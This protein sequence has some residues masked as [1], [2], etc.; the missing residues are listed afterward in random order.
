MTTK[1]AAFL[2]AVGMP[3]I[4]VPRH[5]GD[6]PTSRNDEQVRLEQADIAARCQRGFASLVQAPPAVGVN[7]Q[8]HLINAT[9]CLDLVHADALMHLT[10]KTD[11]NQWVSSVLFDLHTMDYDEACAA[12]LQDHGLFQQAPELYIG[13]LHAYWVDSTTGYT[14]RH[15]VYEHNWHEEVV[16]F[17]LGHPTYELS[18]NFGVGVV[19][20]AEAEAFHG[21]LAFE[22]DAHE[23]HHERVYVEET[24]EQTPEQKPEKTDEEWRACI[25][26]ALLGL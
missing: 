23:N 25:D 3:R 2:A 10:P 16:P 4:G 18:L 8:Y 26:P 17:L 22:N 11:M 5:A 6:R 21:D 20:V 7:P 12:I 9:L 15:E 14:L 19:R 24:S 1:P 13:V